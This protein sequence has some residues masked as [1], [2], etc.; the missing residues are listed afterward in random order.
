MKHQNW[1]L[2]LPL[3]QRN[4]CRRLPGGCRFRS[5]RPRAPW[6]GRAGSG[7]FFGPGFRAGD[8]NTSVFGAVP[9]GA[10]RA[11]A[12]LAVPWAGTARPPAAHRRA[13]RAAGPAAASRKP[14]NPARCTVN[15][16]LGQTACSL[17]MRLA[18]A[19]GLTGNVPVTADPIHNR[20]VAA[21]TGRGTAAQ[22]AAAF[23][24]IRFDGKCATFRAMI[25]RLPI[26]SQPGESPW[27]CPRRSGL[28]VAP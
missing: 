8:C 28:V 6:P 10:Q 27:L 26:I 7:P 25:G 23:H 1:R 3:R 15:G 9:A 16:Q 20:A 12:S 14:G 21:D 5:R 22:R 24:A 11:E 17:R 19:T 13:S 2:T 18:G 4:S